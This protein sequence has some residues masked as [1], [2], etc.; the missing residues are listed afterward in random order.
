[1]GAS[2]WSVARANRSCRV[3]VTGVST[4]PSPRQPYAYGSYD[5]AT[6]GANLRRRVAASSKVRAPS[7][8][9]AVVDMPSRCV[10]TDLKTLGHFA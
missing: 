1:M 7:E 10:H 3:S 6:G 9:Y 8:T 4:E 5:E 2:H